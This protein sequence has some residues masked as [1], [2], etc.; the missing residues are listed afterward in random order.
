MTVDGEVGGNRRKCSWL[1]LNP[2]VKRNIDIK[3]LVQCRSHRM[4]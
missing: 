1:I 3:V 4:H 2:L